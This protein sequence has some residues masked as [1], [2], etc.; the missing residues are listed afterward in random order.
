MTNIELEER[1]NKIES[2][3]T[4]SVLECNKT[5]KE[6]DVI[7]YK[8][9]VYVFNINE[10]GE[11]PTLLFTLVPSADFDDWFVTTVDCKVNSYAPYALGIYIKALQ[12]IKQYLIGKR[13]KNDTRAE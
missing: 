6:D 5:H 2:G 7:Y 11:K 13:A 9:F 4:F 3:V 12:I 10:N 8:G 1:L